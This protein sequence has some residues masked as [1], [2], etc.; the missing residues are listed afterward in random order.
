MVPDAAGGHFRNGILLTPW[1]ADEVVRQMVDGGPADAAFAPG[2]FATLE[3]ARDPVTTAVVAE[4][5]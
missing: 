3:R 4:G 1:T 5:A 2:R